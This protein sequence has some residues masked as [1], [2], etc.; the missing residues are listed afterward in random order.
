MVNVSRTQVCIRFQK[1]RKEGRKEER[2]KLANHYRRVHRQEIK[3]LASLRTTYASSDR[4]TTTIEDR[5]KRIE[6]LTYKIKLSF[7]RPVNHYLRVSVQAAKRLTSGSHLVTLVCRC[8]A[9]RY[10]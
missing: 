2:Q 8:I 10:R 6:K 4:R 1:E 5:R 7:Q 9:R 3:K